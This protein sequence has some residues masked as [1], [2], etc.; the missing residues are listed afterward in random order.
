MFLYFI[1]KKR[2]LYFFVPLKNSN[3]AQIKSAIF[4]RQDSFCWVLFWK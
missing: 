1:T 4:Y 2:K 3:F